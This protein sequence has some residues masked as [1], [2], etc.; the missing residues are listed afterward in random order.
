MGTP[1]LVMMQVVYFKFVILPLKYHPRFFFDN[2]LMKLVRERSQEPI[3]GWIQA[4]DPA[5]NRNCRY[6]GNSLTLVRNAQIGFTF[7]YT[8]SG[9]I[10]RRGRTF[11]FDQEQYVS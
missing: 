3:I 8:L 1:C 11:I 5:N 4:K 9:Q 2:G 7:E 10:V 6:P